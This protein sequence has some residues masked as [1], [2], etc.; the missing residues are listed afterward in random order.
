MKMTNLDI[1][2]TSVVLDNAFNQLN[3]TLPIRVG[4][5]L[6]KNLATLRE[7]AREIDDI[8]LNILRTYGTLSEDGSQYVI[9]DPEKLDLAQ[10]EFSDL[11]A[12]EQEVSIYKIGI[13]K[14][15]DDI[16]LTPAQ[17]GYLMFMLE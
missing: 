10:K 2:N 1:Y 4:F 9:N 5:Y 17:M 15:P 6:Q 13:D 16:G 11:F 7:M 14:F 3:V 12:L 8:R